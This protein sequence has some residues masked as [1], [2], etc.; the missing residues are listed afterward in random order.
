MRLRALAGV[1]TTLVAFAALA[2]SAW[3]YFSS[4]GA[5]STLHLGLEGAL[6]MG[7][8]APGDCQGSTFE[9]YLKAA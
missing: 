3:A 8:N 7:T 4:T 9:I 6:K 2:V 5:G 1:V